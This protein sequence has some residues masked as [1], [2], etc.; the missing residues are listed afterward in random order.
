MSIAVFNFYFP[1]LYDHCRTTVNELRGRERHLDRPFGN[2][3]YTTCT[4][5]MGPQ[6]TSTDHVD[7][8]NSPHVM[9]GVTS[10]GPYDHKRGGHFVHYDL[11]LI[12]E[13]PSGWTVLLPSASL[14]H[15]NTRIQKG[16][17]RYSITQYIP[18]GLFRW[19]RHKFRLAKDVP[20]EERAELDGSSEDRIRQ[21][22]SLFSKF[23]ELDGDRMR[24]ASL[25]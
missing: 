5:N 1:K 19:V 10:L 23:D 21:A 17:R 15:G 7:N 16:E 3:I 4:V 2:S 12:I 13:F 22:W 11:K 14:R 8:L 9:C 24:F 6:S 18:G 20:D 25:D